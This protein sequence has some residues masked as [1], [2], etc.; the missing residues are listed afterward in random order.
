MMTTPAAAAIKRRSRRLRGDLP[1]GITEGLS[2]MFTAGR[3][4]GRSGGEVGRR[5]MERQAWAPCGGDPVGPLP[6]RIDRVGWLRDRPPAWAST[7][8]WTHLGT[9]LLSGATI[10][11]VQGN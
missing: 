4:R 3:R 5:P 8:P 2:L 9:P 6:V 10:A 1:L 7:S 11:G